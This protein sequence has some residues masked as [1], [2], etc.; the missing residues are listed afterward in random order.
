MQ[1]TKPQFLKHSN[2]LSVVCSIRNIDSILNGCLK[3]N[4]NEILQIGHVA[5][6]VGANNKCCITDSHNPFKWQP[7][8]QEGQTQFSASGLTLILWVHSNASTWLVL[9]SRLASL[10]LAPII[11]YARDIT[12][13]QYCLWAQILNSNS[14]PK[15]VPTKKLL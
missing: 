10:R 1:E 12:Y 11:K 4:G 15:L 14:L 7:H 9:Y 13:C 6:F 3:V 2:H 5:A 8:F